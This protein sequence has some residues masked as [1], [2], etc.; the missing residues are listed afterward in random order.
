MILVSGMSCVCVRVRGEVS[1]TW[2]VCCTWCVILVSGMWCV[3]VLGEMSDTW[4]VCV[5]CSV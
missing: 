5:V 4:C 3:C 2:C 1:G